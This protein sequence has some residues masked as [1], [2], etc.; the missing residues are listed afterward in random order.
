MIT[1][2]PVGCIPQFASV[3]S[4]LACQPQQGRAYGQWTKLAS[5]TKILHQQILA[6]KVAQL[7]SSKI[8]HRWR[9]SATPSTQVQVIRLSPT[10]SIAHVSRHNTLSANLSRLY[11]ISSIRFNRQ[12]PSHPR[13]CHASNLSLNYTLFMLL[14]GL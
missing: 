10:K 1:S 11:H 14:G 6:G 4:N 12:F 8:L 3:L 7:K 9:R 5:A 2:Q 13:F